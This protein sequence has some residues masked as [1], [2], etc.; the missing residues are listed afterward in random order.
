VSKP[1]N[2]QKHALECM[3]L[4]SDCMQLAHDVE[5]QHLRSH[6]VRMAAEW[7]ALADQGQSQ[8]QVKLN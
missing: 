7:S 8:V 4:A 6:F 3:R 1:Y 2:T 5:S